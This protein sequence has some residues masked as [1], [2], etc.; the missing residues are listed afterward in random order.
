MPRYRFHGE[1][2]QLLPSGLRH[3]AFE[4]ASSEHVTVKHVI[5]TLGVPHTEVGAILI[6]GR[7]AGL[8]QQIGDSDAIEVH[9]AMFLAT[10]EHPRQ[11]RFLADAHLGG[12]ARRLRLLGFDTVLAT[13]APDRLLAELAER[14]SRIVLS[15]NR[16]LLKHRRVRCGRFVRA[17]ATDEQIHEVVS[18]F[19]LRSCLRRFTRCLLDLRVE[20]RRN[21]SFLSTTPGISTVGRG[22]APLSASTPS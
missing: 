4:R 8:G 12:L 14:D 1:L 10:A 21:Q 22:K 5:E 15:R 11:P 6:N 20:A 7:P 2:N 3:R 16:E 18:H 17:L 13:D 19:R 9:P